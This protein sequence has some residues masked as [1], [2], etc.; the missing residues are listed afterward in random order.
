MFVGDGGGPAPSALQ[1]RSLLQ[2]SPGDSPALELKL[3][4]LVVL[5]CVTLLFGFAP[6]WL[7]R[8]AGLCCAGPGEWSGASGP[9]LRAGG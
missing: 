2:V 1:Q 7:V 5:L 9:R 4:A 6:F 8:G 3:G